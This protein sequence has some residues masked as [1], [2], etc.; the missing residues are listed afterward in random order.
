MTTEVRKSSMYRELLW[1]M[2][3]GDHDNAR[4]IHGWGEHIYLANYLAY[5]WRTHTG[6]TL[7]FDVR[8][9]LAAEY[10]NRYLGET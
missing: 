6:E 2:M 9:A 3:P 10:V 5:I 1:Y 4:N 8:G 7:P